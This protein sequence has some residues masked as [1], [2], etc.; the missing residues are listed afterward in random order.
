[1][2]RE[3]DGIARE[4]EEWALAAAIFHLASLGKRPATGR[5][6]SVPAR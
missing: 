5:A 6:T 4:D 1:M 2:L 3:R